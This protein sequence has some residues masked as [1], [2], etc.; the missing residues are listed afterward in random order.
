MTLLG[1]AA[2]SAGAAGGYPPTTTTST[3]GPTSAS[4]GASYIVGDHFTFQIC[5]F[6][7]DSNV[8]DTW[9]SAPEGTILIDPNGCLTVTIV[10]FDPHVT[11]D[12]GALIA[13]N[14]GDNT[15]FASGTGANGAGRTYTYVVDIVQPSSGSGSTAAGSTSSLAFTGLDVALMSGAGLALIAVGLLLVLGS[16]RRRSDPGTPAGT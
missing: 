14:W 1:V 11:I 9:N 13:A 4:G 10:I 12:G 3:I 2:S 8:S 15:F 7:P 6:L 16:R 5:G